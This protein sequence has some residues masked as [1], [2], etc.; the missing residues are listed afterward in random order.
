MKDLL[1]QNEII[2]DIIQFQKPMKELM[3]FTKVTNPAE[4]TIHSSSEP[5]LQ[6]FQGK[7][8]K[9]IDSILKYFQGI[10]PQKDLPKELFEFIESLSF[11]KNPKSVQK[12]TQLSKVFIENELSQEE[13]GTLIINEATITQNQDIV[14]NDESSIKLDELIRTIW[15]LICKAY[16]Q[17]KIYILAVLKFILLMLIQYAIENRLDFY[18]KDNQPLD[19]I[20][21]NQKIIIKQNQEILEKLNKKEN[22]DSDKSKDFSEII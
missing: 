2:N 21:E 5:T 4:W 1:D 15:D 10:V 12:I 7:N 18:F 6:A 17:K 3:A 20:F 16:H 19:Q 8:L 22:N 11:T 14:S 9:E 13:F